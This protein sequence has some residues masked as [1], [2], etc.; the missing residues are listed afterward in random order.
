MEIQFQSDI[1]RR[2][3]MNQDYTNVFKNQADISLAILADGMGGHLAGDVASQMV[4]TGL[5]SAWQETSISAAEETADWMR[6]NIQKA[7]RKVY[8]AGQS[9][10]EYAGMGTTVVAAVLLEE[11]AIIANVGDSRAYLLRDNELS[12]ITEDHSWVNEL[13]KS[14]EITKEAAERHPQKNVLIRT[15]GMPGLIDVD[16]FTHYW[17]KKDYILLCSDGLTNMV[18][19]KEIV[20]ILMG[21]GTLHEKISALIHQANAAGGADNITVLIIQCGEDD[22]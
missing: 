13:V 12:Q 11:Q 16:I 1:G 8:E 19:E 6:Q 5:G 17:Q 3:N 2:R 15:V 22:Q 10:P 9:K 4:V 20:E 18:S 14:G 7:N 21:A